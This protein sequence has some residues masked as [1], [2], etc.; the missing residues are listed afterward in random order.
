MQRMPS[1]TPSHSF[2]FLRSRSAVRRARASDIKTTTCADHPN[3]ENQDGRF[4][5]GKWPPTYPTETSPLNGGGHLQPQR[6][7]EHVVIFLCTEF[8]EH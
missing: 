4:H 7:I 5:K 8:V 3:Q 2:L 1:A 6:D